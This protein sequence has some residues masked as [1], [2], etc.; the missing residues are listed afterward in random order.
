V[1]QR[2]AAA[3]EPPRRPED[4]VKVVEGEIVE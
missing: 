3:P 1:F 4:E 2:V